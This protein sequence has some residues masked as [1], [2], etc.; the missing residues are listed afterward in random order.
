MAGSLYEELGVPRDAPAAA[1]RKAYR[2]AAAKVH[3]DVGGSRER[4]DRVKLAHDVLTDPLRRLTYDETGRVDEKPI[5]NRQAESMAM[6]MQA[7]DEVVAECER[8]FGSPDGVDVVADAVRK[9]EL[10]LA[11]IATERQK[12]VRKAAEI[13]RLGDRFKGKR[14]NPNVITPMFAA[15]AA[16]LDRAVTRYNHGE[17]IT[18]LAIG[19]LKGHVCETS[20]APPREAPQRVVLSHFFAAPGV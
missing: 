3:P 15:K 10:R 18:R 12:G 17:E 6:V 9:L 7:V 2:R 4:F 5:D 20:G 16:E 8:R 1:V 13:R 14:W 19:I 11:S